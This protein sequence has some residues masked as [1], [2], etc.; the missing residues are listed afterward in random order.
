MNRTQINKIGDETREFTMDTTKIQ[1]IIR[2]R[3]ATIC[4]QNG[5]LRKKNGQILK[6]HNLPR[7]NQ[8]EIY[9]QNNHK[10]AETMIK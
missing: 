3:H 9:E 5:K 7:L 10:F 4:Q 6:M 2:L 8:E 1:R